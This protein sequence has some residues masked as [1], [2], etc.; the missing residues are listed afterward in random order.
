MTSS[1]LSIVTVKGISKMKYDE[2]RRISR[3]LTRVGKVL[4]KDFTKLDSTV[5]GDSI[6]TRLHTN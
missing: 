1:V 6:S 3:W 2:R 4:L 5:I